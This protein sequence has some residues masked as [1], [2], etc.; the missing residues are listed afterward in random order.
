MV[1]EWRARGVAETQVELD[2]GRLQDAAAQA[3]QLWP[4][5]RLPAPAGGSGGVGY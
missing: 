4:D 2:A 3:I 5:K 1:V